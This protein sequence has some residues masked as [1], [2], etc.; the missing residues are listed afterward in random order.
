M[1]I[2]QWRSGLKTWLTQNLVVDSWEL[3]NP[4]EYGTTNGFISPLQGLVY[5]DDQ[6]GT[7]TANQD[8]YLT[9]RYSGDILYADLPLGNLE[10]LYTMV[11]R[12]L[13]TGYGDIAP[14]LALEMLSVADCISI[15]EYGDD[16]ADWLV[17]LTFSMNISWIPTKTPLPGE[18]A[19][20]VPGINR[21][22]IGLFA[23]ELSS[24]NHLDPTTRDKVG[25]IPVN[26]I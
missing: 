13:V 3:R 2:S 18:I 16:I 15:A 11:A 23:E 22:K 24:T 21:I 1:N 4:T 6:T 10:Q 19:Q 20:P 14:L 5:V 26:L 12:K 9:S 8:I 17:T 7:C 25:E